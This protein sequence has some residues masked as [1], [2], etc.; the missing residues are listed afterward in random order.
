MKTQIKILG[1]AFVA[2]ILYV[3]CSTDDVVTDIP[4]TPPSA[5][6]MKD[7]RAAALSKHSQVFTLSAL[8]SIKQFTS[9]KGVKFTIK[10]NNLRL[11]GNPVT[12]DVTIDY[13]EI[14]DGGSMLT[15]HKTTMG[16]L[17][18]GVM[19]MI[20][21]GGEFFLNGKAN[22]KQLDLIAPVP[23]IIPAN[24]TGQ[25]DP[26]M[27]LWNGNIDNDGNI[28]WVR[29]DVANGA[30]GGVK[31]DGQGSNANYFATFSQFGWT[32]VDKFYSDPRPKTTIQA[33]VPSGYT[34]SNCAIYLHYDGEPN[35]L[36]LLDTYNSSTG[37]FSE[38]YGQIPIG[39]A[40][41]IIFATEENGQWRYAIKAATITANATYSF[42]LAETTVVSEAQLVSA[43][44]A[45][46]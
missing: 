15:T 12:G 13:A 5:Q 23:F 32:N 7:L 11:N 44:N 37:I 46:P 41:H 14:F 29:K 20:I 42:T 39:L 34:N 33:T 40:C 28:D 35:G 31:V 36:A 10:R 45:L 21:S 30:A 2:S 18:G 1:L 8:D 24:L 4:L 17:G 25:A 6:E 43:I 22:G 9:P 3:S 16:D 27:Q 19:G 38:H 26:A